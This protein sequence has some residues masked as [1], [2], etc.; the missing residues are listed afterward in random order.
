MPTLPPTSMVFRC[1]V[2]VN[3]GRLK[4][5]VA[6]SFGRNGAN[7]RYDAKTEYNRADVLV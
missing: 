5:L 3:M 6:T 7:V 1:R 2:T 4:E